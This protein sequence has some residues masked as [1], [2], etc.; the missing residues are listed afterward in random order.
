MYIYIQERHSFLAAFSSK[1]VQNLIILSITV[2]FF[3]NILCQRS[4]KDYFS[5]LSQMKKIRKTEHEK[6]IDE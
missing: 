1:K 6:N 2:Y 3:S 4:D 5:S